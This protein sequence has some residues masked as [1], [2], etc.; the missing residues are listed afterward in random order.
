MK[1][2]LLLIAI[3]PVL[4]FSCEDEDAIRVPELQ[5]GA[6]MRIQVNPDNSFL[7]FAELSTAS[8]IFNLYSV[9]LD[10]I[11]RTQ[12]FLQYVNL[13]QD[14]IYDRVEI[15]NFTPGDFDSDGAIKGITFTTADLLTAYSIASQDTLG[16]GD[17]LNFYN[18]TTM[19]DGRVYPDTILAGTDLETVNIDPSAFGIGTTSSFSPGFLAYI[20]CPSDAADWEGDYNSC[21]SNVNNFCG[22]LDC[23]S[24]RD[25][26]INA[27]YNPEPFAYS[28]EGHDAGLW[29]SFDPNSYDREGRIYD[30]CDTPVLLPSATGYGDHQDVGGGTKD[31]STGVFSYNWC[32]FFNPV[33]GTTTFTPIPE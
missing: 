28:L 13:A 2:Y 15:F 10:E 23:G 24:C 27:D 6:T 14:S 3:L 31:T 19:T 20:A 4:F 7:N 12:I 30:I 32:N 11:A 33:C 8:I 16:G 18:V 22:L 5:N 25:A 29:G 26:E 21:V 9:N 1:K 17:I